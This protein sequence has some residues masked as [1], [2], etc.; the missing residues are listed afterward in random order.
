MHTDSFT[1]G[2]VDMYEAY[3]IRVVHYDLLLPKLRPRKVTIPQRSGEYDFGARYH[4]ERVLLLECD[5]RNSLTR[6]QLRELA[7]ALS[8][9]N[10]IVLWDEPEK[11]YIGQLYMHLR[12]PLHVNL[13]PMEKRS[14]NLWP[15]V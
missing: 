15:A 2:G 9:K 8:K 14:W 11:Y 4:D 12:F 10:R 13:M 3:G 1:F 6:A 7:Y 5:S